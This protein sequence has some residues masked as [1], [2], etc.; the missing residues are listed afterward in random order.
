MQ[1]KRETQFIMKSQSTKNNPALT[2]VGLELT[3]KDMKRTLLLFSM[4][5]KVRDTEVTKKMT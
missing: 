4:C 3:D 2:T 1:R 5:L